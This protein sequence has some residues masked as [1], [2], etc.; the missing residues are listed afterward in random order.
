M[1]TGPNRIMDEFAKLMTDAAGAAQG[2]RREIETA[3][4]AHAERWLNSL[5]IVKREEFEAVREMAIKARDEN[6]A[7]L[8]RIEALEARLSSKSK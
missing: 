3:F 7:L 4:N 5:D 8:A 2:V 1:S 6:E